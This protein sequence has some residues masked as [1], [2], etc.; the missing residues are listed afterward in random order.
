MPGLG[1]GLREDEE[2]VSGVGIGD[3]DLLAVED[4]CAAGAACCRLYRRNVRACVR[5]SQPVARQL[6]ARGHRHQPALLL[7]LVS[8]RVQAHADQADV[9]RQH[10]GVGGVD[11]L[12]LLADEPEGQVVEAVAAVALR[13]AD[14]RE[15]DRS[16]LGE[17]LGVVPALAIVG[18]DCGRELPGAEVPDRGHELLLVRRQRQ[19]EHQR[20][21]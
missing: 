4:V 1:I 10:C 3:P 7:L 13:E 20:I 17:D 18:R 6:L 5:L 8:P 14:A 2:E 16:E 12:E 19:V 15:P 11:V 9:H 21:T